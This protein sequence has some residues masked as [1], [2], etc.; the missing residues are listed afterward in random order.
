MSG[1]LPR[2]VTDLESSGHCYYGSLAPWLGALQVCALVDDHQ[3]DARSEHSDRGL[4][5]HCQ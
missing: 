1:A 3:N 4:K 5:N 2:S